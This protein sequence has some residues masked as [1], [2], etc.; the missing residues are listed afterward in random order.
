MQLWTGLLAVIRLGGP[1]S[2]LAIGAG[3]QL[4]A[5]V[6]GLHTSIHLT[7]AHSHVVTQAY[8]HVGSCRGSQ[9]HQDRASSNA[10]ALS[11]PLL[12]MPDSV[13]L[14]RA[15]H[16]VKPRVSVGGDNKRGCTQGHVSEVRA[17]TAAQ[18]VHEFLSQLRRKCVTTEAHEFSKQKTK[19]VAQTSSYFT[20]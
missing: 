14:A 17:T 15:S 6:T 3:Y 4:V 1:H 12:I 16:T 11:K 5:V 10:Q 9:E 8:S 7:W 19:L 18:L 20:H 2:C 13:L